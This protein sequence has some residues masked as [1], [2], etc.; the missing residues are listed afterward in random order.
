MG[1]QRADATDSTPEPNLGGRTDTGVD[2]SNL[3]INDDT[4]YVRGAR[5]LTGRWTGLSAIQQRWR[6][7]VTA[8]TLRTACA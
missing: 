3:C 1:P 6:G 7:Q 8:A 4:L 5:A 2:Y